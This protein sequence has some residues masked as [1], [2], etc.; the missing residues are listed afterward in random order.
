MNESYCPEPKIGDLEKSS[1][2]ALGF[3]KLGRPLAPNG[4][5]SRYQNNL[6]LAHE[7]HTDTFITWFGDWI[8]DPGNASVAVYEDTGEPML[9]KHRSQTELEK[10][11]KLSIEHDK[12]FGTEYGLLMKATY[13]TTS[14]LPEYGPFV[15]YAFL[16]L[17]NPNSEWF[18]VTSQNDGVFLRGEDKGKLFYH[19]CV[20]SDEQVLE[21]SRQNT[22]L[23]GKHR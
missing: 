21:I 3:D 22:S 1:S 4:E 23:S 8:N 13:F 6:K 5:I 19:A 14:D 10:D 11:S 12:T 15:H 18:L 2:R 17:R 16:N 7:I 20:F 9:F